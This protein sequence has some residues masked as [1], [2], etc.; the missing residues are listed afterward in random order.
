MEPNYI[1]DLS[2]HPSGKRKDGFQFFI[3]TA[4]LFL[5]SGIHKQYEIKNNNFTLLSIEVLSLILQLLL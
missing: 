3:E 5:S 1:Q 2:K 4:C